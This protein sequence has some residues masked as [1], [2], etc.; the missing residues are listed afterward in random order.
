M[1][2]THASDAPLRG[3][4]AG[5]ADQLADARRA[6]WLAWLVLVL[7]LAATAWGWHFARASGARVAHS[8]FE[9]RVDDVVSAIR[10]RLT[11]YEQTLRG[12]AALFGADRGRVSR[13]QWRAYVGHL[14]IEQNYPG[15][16]GLGYAQVFAA[17]EQARREARVRRQGFPDFHV[18]PSGGAGDLRS[19]IV[20]LEPFDWRNQRAFGYD[21]FSEPVRRAAME[22]ARDSGRAAISGKI[23][24]VQETSRE[25]QSGFVMY[26]PV[27]RAGAPLDNLAERRK[28]LQGFVY[29]PFRMDDLMR[30]I[31]GGRPP[32]LALEVFDGSRADP[33]ARMYGHAAQGT[34]RAAFRTSRT[35][36]VNGHRWTLRLTSLPLFD[37]QLTGMRPWFVLGA[38]VLISLLLFAI[39]WSMAHTRARALQLAGKMT[40]TLRDRKAQLR[41]ITS[42]LGEAV[43]VEDPQGRITFVNPAAVELLGWSETELL[44][45]EA[46][47]LFHARDGQGQAL[48]PQ[49]CAILACLRS[50]RTYRSDDEVFWTR[51]GRCFPATVTATPI[52]R[53]GTIA[54]VVV[55]F[56]DITERKRVERALR[57]TERFR[58][59]FQYSREALFLTEPDGRIVDANRVA[60]DSLDYAPEELIGT[61]ADRVVRYQG[62][63]SLCSFAEVAA[64]LERHGRI[65]MEAEHV[66]RD[67]SSYPVEVVHSHI[68]VDGRTLLL[69]AARDISE[70]K[71]AEGL[72]TQL[73][74]LVD[75]SFNEIYLFDAQSLRFVQVNQGALRNLGYTMEE[76]RGMT[77]VDLK[78]YRRAEFEALL[79]SLREGR[80]DLVV[81]ETRHRRKDGSEYPVEVRLQFSPAERPPVFMA[82]V[83]DITVRKAGESELAATLEA[84]ARAKQEAEEAN[85]QLAQSN[86][87]LMRLAQLDGL[88]G[89]ANRRYFDEYLANE[90]RRAARSGAG[91][92]LVLADVDHFKAYNDRYGHQAGDECLR[93]VAAAL[94]DELGRAGDLLARYGGE[95]FVLVLPDTP[96]DGACAIAETMRRAVQMLGVPHAASPT[97]ECVTLSLGVAVVQAEPDKVPELLIACADRALYDA[98]KTGRNRVDAYRAGPG[99]S[100]VSGPSGA[101]KGLI[102]RH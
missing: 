6:R 94:C 35:L 23:R 11:A 12:G 1:P 14:N 63:R 10:G 36:A 62:E 16:L 40:A 89:I 68:E 8:Q 15:I 64:Q 39:T 61:H 58:A 20:Y 48:A 101:G 46:H 50:G 99:L 7:A 100:L 55:A 97:A 74:R 53:E 78:P 19:A 75:A 85:E 2:P 87:E 21:M 76:M 66:R 51:E 29:S 32:D 49:D 92:A 60:C 45:A 5:I 22:H 42:T 4:H 57:E 69:V 28:A 37:A 65:S 30:G 96:L 47:S 13:R 83:Q 77:P 73:G 41:E 33:A 31:F 9:A 102:T 82:V 44:G 3:E 25:V 71:R 86:M 81:F 80:R 93:R 88:T 90:W 43:L 59:L 79:A 98:K 70:R 34:G 95:E 72:A 38:G 24:L 27:Y 18:W 91:V 17:G 84:L 54:G 67:G 26:L 52:L 56:S